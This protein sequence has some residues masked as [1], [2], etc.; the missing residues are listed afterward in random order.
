MSKTAKDFTDG[1]LGQ[2]S[3][4]EIAGATAIPDHVKT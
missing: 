1:Y 4:I 2:T 3:G